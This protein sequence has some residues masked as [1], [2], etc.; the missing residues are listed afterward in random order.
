VLREDVPVPGELTRALGRHAVHPQ[1]NVA[2]EHGVMVVEVLG[3]EDA[4]HVDL[5]QPKRSCQQQP[6][7]NQQQGLLRVGHLSLGNGHELQ[8][9]FAVDG[10][11]DLAGRE[12]TT[13]LDVLQR[14]HTGPD[15][16]NVATTHDCTTQVQEAARTFWHCCQFSLASFRDRR[17]L[18]IRFSSSASS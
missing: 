12:R 9:A 4:L 7:N 2:A 5:S 3:E 14:T 16:T 1:Q 11:L 13:L 10:V 18:L 17:I 6:T 15:E 8:L